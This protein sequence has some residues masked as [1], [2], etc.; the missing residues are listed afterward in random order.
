MVR[1]EGAR[2]PPFTISTI[3]YKVVMYAQ[4]AAERAGT[5]PYFYSTRVCTLWPAVPVWRS[6]E[7]WESRGGVTTEREES[8]S[9][10]ENGGGVKGRGRRRIIAEA[11]RG[12]RGRG[13]GGWRGGLLS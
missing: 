11:E 3:T 2:P 8:E 9:R 12:Q 6:N 5:F 10:E 4:N 7:L 1:V 13:G